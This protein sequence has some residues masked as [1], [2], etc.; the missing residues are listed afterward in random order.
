[1]PPC[2][3]FFCWDVCLT[4]FFAQV[5]LE[6][7]SSSSSVVGITG[8]CH[9]TQLLVEIRVSRTFCLG[10]LQTSICWISASQ[11]ARITGMNHQ[12]LA[13]LWNFWMLIM[14]FAAPV[15]CVSFKSS[16]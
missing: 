16:K 14:F 12:H 15:E 9:C 7:W 3:G 1:V 5:G 4:N 11:I 2:S 13:H 10:W 8:M 6:L